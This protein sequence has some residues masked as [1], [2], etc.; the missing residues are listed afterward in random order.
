[1]SPKRCREKCRFLIITDMS[2]QKV[3]SWLENDKLCRWGQYKDNKYRSPRQDL[4]GGQPRRCGWFPVRQWGSG[5]QGRGAWALLSRGKTLLWVFTKRRD[6]PGS[7]SS[8]ILR[9]C[10]DREEITKLSHR[11]AV[12]QGRMPRKQ[13][14]VCPQW[15]SDCTNIP[16]I[17]TSLKLDSSRVV[18]RVNSSHSDSHPVG[19]WT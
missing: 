8:F 11:W 4:Y 9:T 6:E 19:V 10:T 12:S 18:P 13:P 2:L 16:P 3:L 7:P 1:M 14:R 5:S 15:G 17:Q